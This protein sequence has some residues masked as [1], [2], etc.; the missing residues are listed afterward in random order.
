[1]MENGSPKQ[2]ENTGASTSW[3]DRFTT[4]KQAGEEND[5]Y[6]Y[7]GMLSTRKEKPLGENGPVKNRVERRD[8][9]H[10]DV[11]AFM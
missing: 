8:G 5:S 2:Q 1:M 7:T 11:V 3:K 4:S 10:W 6:I 9:F